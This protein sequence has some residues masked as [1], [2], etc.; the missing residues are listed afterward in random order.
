MSI[1]LY[2]PSGMVI[3]IVIELVLFVCIVDNSAARKK[4]FLP[5]FYDL[6][7]SLK[8]LNHTLVQPLIHVAY[9]LDWVKLKNPRGKVRYGG[10]VCV[11][12]CVLIYIL[13]PM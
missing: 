2:R 10:D 8:L 5:H 6:A 3:K 9:M 7:K 12:C 4:I 11:V 1:A 13:I